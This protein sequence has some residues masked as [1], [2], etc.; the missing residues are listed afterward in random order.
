MALKDATRSYRG[1]QNAGSV[2]QCIPR[3]RQDYILPMLDKSCGITNEYLSFHAVKACAT[4]SKSYSRDVLEVLGDLQTDPTFS[5]WFDGRA[6]ALHIHRMIQTWIPQGT[7]KIN[8][9]MKPLIKHML[10]QE[11]A[12]TADLSTARSAY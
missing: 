9:A 12:N 3:L 4:R 5:E 11:P 10:R 1:R 8:Q 6:G 2:V 7:E